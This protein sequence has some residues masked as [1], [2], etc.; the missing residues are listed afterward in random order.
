VKREEDES[1]SE[2]E[3]TGHRGSTDPR[4]AGER[5]KEEIGSKSVNEI[6]K[7]KGGAECEK[8]VRKNEGERTYK[9]KM[10]K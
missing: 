7:Q 10:R 6:S 4:D 5:E 9:P 2:E 1:R 3:Y 8:E